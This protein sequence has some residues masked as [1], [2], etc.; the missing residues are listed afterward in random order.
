MLRK[1]L[2]I[3]CLPISQ[4]ADPLMLVVQ[5]CWGRFC[6][7][8]SSQSANQLMLVVHKENEGACKNVIFLMQ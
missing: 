1:V 5:I 4:L 7:S 3:F 8:S 6:P 2:P